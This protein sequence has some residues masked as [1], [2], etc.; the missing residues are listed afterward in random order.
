MS[1]AEQILLSIALALDCF[2]VSVTLGIIKRRIEYR[3]MLSSSVLFG[4]FQGAMPLAG[5]LL[6]GLFSDTLQMFDRWIAFFM[7]LFIGGK[8]IV[9]NLPFGN[10]TKEDEPQSKPVT[11]GFILALAV[12]T[13]IDALAIGPALSCTGFKTLPSLVMPL[14]I[15]AAGSF[16]LSVIG[17]CIGSVI[18]SHIRFRFEPIGGIVLISIGIKILLSI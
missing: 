9:E 7:L 6:I 16:I 8:M 17:N 13:S 10:R 15:I 14:S 2:T 12:A 5:W 3:T 11:M 18:G 1:I 4:I